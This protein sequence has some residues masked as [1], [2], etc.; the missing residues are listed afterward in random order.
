MNKIEKHK[1]EEMETNDR[2]IRNGKIIENRNKI[3]KQ[4]V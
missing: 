1:Y 2:N 3:E 4:K